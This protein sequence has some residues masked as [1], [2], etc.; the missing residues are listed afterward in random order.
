MNNEI[1]DNNFNKTINNNINNNNDI[2]GNNMNNILN[3]NIININFINNNIHE[4]IT[5][6]KEKKFRKKK[7]RKKKKKRKKMYAKSDC[8]DN[9]H[10]MN[11]IQLEG[12]I[13]R[14]ESNQYFNNIS[15]INFYRDKLSEYRIDSKK[16]EINK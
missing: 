3:K 8:Y 12:K 5:E 13:Y 4:T 15:K 1:I 2:L 14:K 16:N 9:N 7:F 10:L 6:N 11:Q